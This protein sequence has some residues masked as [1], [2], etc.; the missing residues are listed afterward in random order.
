MTMQDELDDL[1][2]HQLYEESIEPIPEPPTLAA[3]HAAQ[4]QASAFQAQ[5]ASS[6]NTSPTPTSRRSP[7]SRVNPRSGIDNRRLQIR[8]GISSFPSIP[9]QPSREALTANVPSSTSS[10]SARVAALLEKLIIRTD[11]LLEALQAVNNVFD[12]QAQLAQDAALRNEVIE[13]D[14]ILS[15]FPN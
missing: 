14:T 15:T 5:A 1:F 3:R 11:V 2:N 12:N 9:R 10:N 8:N 13:I 4:P 6:L 7:R